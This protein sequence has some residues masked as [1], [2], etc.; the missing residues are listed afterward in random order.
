MY[1]KHLQEAPALSQPRIAQKSLAKKIKVGSSYQKQI[2]S[3]SR[4]NR[5][6]KVGVGNT[7]SLL[8]MNSAGHSNA[9]KK[10]SLYT[11]IGNYTSNV[12]QQT[13]NSLIMLN[14][15]TQHIP[16]KNMLVGTQHSL[17]SSSHGFDG[18]QIQPGQIMS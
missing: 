13:K 1:F 2:A 12:P 15:S 14:Q 9:R 8:V 16:N 7:G 4:A 17:N 5:N 6:K 18:V 11:S 10:R 3:A